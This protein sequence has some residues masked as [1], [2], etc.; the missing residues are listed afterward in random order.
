MFF[1]VPKPDEKLEIPVN[2]F[3]RNEIKIMTSY[4]AAPS[5]LKESIRII[6]SGKLNLKE[7]ITHK[8]KFDEIQEGFNLV[9]EAKESLKVIIE[10]QK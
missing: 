2:D 5:D 4:G 1:A 7:M 9:A 8:L 6:S 3:W 10:P